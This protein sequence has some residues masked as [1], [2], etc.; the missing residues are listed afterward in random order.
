VRKGG[1]E[2]KYHAHLCC[3]NKEKRER[4]EKHLSLILPR[5]KKNIE[6]GTFP[7][8]EHYGREKQKEGK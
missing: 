1:R 7:T 2:K 8:S 5:K 6:P 4:E 3:P